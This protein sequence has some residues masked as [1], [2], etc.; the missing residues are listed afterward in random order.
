MTPQPSDPIE[1]ASQVVEQTM[2]SQTRNERRGEVSVFTCPECGGALWQL[3]EPKLLQFRCHVG[4]AYNAETLLAEQT[5][6]L[7]AA[8][9]TAVRTFREKSVLAQQLAT[10]ERA[11]G[12]KES[13][14]K[15][16]ELAA[17][18]AEYARLIIEHVLQGT[19]GGA[20]QRSPVRDSAP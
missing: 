10:Q 11:K 17:Q 2:E 14:V 1:R 6:T 12:N 5:D 18:S 9:W 15:F 8:L 13:A 7:E 19:V 20:A 4:H 3:E 16:D